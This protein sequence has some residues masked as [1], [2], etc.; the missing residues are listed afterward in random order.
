MC[1]IE[2]LVWWWANCG[3]RMALY[4]VN[5][6]LKALRK[7]VGDSEQQIVLSYI[8]R[9]NNVSDF[10]SF[11]CLWICIDSDVVYSQH[12]WAFSVQNICGTWW[13]GPP[14]HTQHVFMWVRFVFANNV[15]RF[16]V[17]L[18]TSSL[19]CSA[20]TLLWSLCVS[21]FS[22][23]TTEKHI[24]AKYTIPACLLFYGRS[25]FIAV[26]AQTY[27]QPKQFMCGVM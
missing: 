8:L 7:Y 11:W 9:I 20:D 4:I 27:S 15:T 5:I 22:A 1:L 18:H 23:L 6:L 13:S 16:Y 26:S 19:W 17:Y 2:L 25:S 3:W 24:L 21:F 12:I 10:V 14:S